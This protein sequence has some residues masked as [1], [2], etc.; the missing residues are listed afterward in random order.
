ML[1]IRANIESINKMYHIS[2]RKNKN[3]IIIL[4]DKEK[5]FYRIQIT[6]MM[7]NLNEWK[8]YEFSS[9]HSKP[10]AINPQHVDLYSIAKKTKTSF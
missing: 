6:L 8:M 4:I 5:R 9:I 1:V 7:N 10:F 3:L 2:K